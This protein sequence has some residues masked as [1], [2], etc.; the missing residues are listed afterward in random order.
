MLPDIGRLVGQVADR[1]VSPACWSA[2]PARVLGRPVGLAGWLIW[3]AFWRQDPW[4]DGLGEMDE[5]EEDFH[6]SPSSDES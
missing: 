4:D 6:Q 1:Q 2:R 3:S 5:Q